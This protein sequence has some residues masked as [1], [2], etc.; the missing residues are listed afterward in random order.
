[1]KAPLP[2]DEARRLLALESYNILDTPPEEGFDDI[3]VLASQICGTPMALV[4]LVDND[5][6]WFKSRLGI[7]VSETPRDLSFCAHALLQADE[8]LIVPDARNDPRFRDNALVTGEE[9]IQFYAGAPLVTPEG[10][11]LGTLCVLDHQPRELS[12]A[13]QK[14][15]RALARQ[16]VAQLE[17]RRNLVRLSN[18]LALHVQ[19][20]ARLRD[21]Q[22]RFEAFMDAS[23]LVA[24]VKDANW[25]F[26][27]VNKPFL[28]RF[29]LT[30]EKVIGHDDFDLWPVEV[31]ADLRAH[32]TQIVEGE[33]IVEILERVPTPDGERF[34]QV[35]KF[36][37][38]RGGGNAR[39]LAGV[40]LD[41][42]Q[43]K[44]YEQQLERYQLELENAL[45]RVEAESRSD[46]LT[47][48]HNRR[49]FDPRLED[50]F[51]RAHRYGVPLSVLMLDVDKFKLFNDSFGH[52]CG[53]EVLQTVARLLS[54]KARTSDFVARLGGE[55]FAILLPNTGA[56]G[57]FI[58]AE[59]MR[60]T[61]ETAPWRLRPITISIGIA[62]HTANSQTGLRLLDQADQALYAAKEGGRNRVTQ[63]CEE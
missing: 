33:S 61:I 13:Q 39:S 43:T 50:E 58:L 41:V 22:T 36:P 40:A 18:A 8:L 32:D 59:R 28:E 45:I 51:D 53:D 42:T 5:R 25:R 2:P 31:A 47:G 11:A 23:P 24:F 10:D 29:N 15:L 35:F 4:S 38:P 1:M 57:A 54:E 34:W 14:A 26:S 62:T 49:A 63:F 56:E 55:E 17:L 60:R 52:G 30:K 46:A 44:H 27:Y 7:T 16:A 20:E 21:S 12:P 6:Q 9:N 19:N 3:V 37:L 48:L